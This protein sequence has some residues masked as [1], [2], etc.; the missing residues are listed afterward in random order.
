MNRRHCAAAA[1]SLVCALAVLAAPVQAM[2]A[3]VPEPTPTAPAAEL[4]S[5]EE[6]RE[7][8][9]TLY[10]K[11]GAATDAYNLAEEQAAEQ[12][13][14]LAEL[15]KAIVDGRARIAEL[16]NTAGAQARE[17]Y[18]NGG[19]PPGAQLVLSNDPRLFLDGVNQVRLSQQASKSVL[20][21]LTRTQ[22]DLETY[23]KDA[24]INWEKLEAHR[25]QQARAKKRINT[26]IAAATELESRL[27]KG[28]RARLLT[29][30]KQAQYQA[31]TAWLSS[32]ALGDISR[33]ASASGRQAVAFATAQ[34]GKPYVWGAEGPDTYD[35]SGLTSQAWAAAERPIPRTSQEQ[36]RL[37]PRVVVQDMRP[38]DLII[39]HAD[40][41]HVGMYV[42]DGLIVHA[43]RPGRNVTLAGAGSMAI[44]GVVRP[45]K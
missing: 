32:G 29:L 2:A 25:L 11:A 42:G 33:E 4:K 40:A 1:I 21:E 22:E 10:R 38:G 13:G 37:L 3:P 34:I 31:Q 18:R 24:S 30:E 35:C 7:E 19:L 9:D 39:Y 36:W 41:S 15:A 44:L 43:P 17:Q 20:A 23:T 28:E 6:V 27:A 26:Q 45:D 8:I 14:E 12:S 5:L 16:K